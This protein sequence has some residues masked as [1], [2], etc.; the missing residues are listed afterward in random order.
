MSWGIMGIILVSAFV[1]TQWVWQLQY[2]FQRGSMNALCPGT[3]LNRVRFE[4]K[5]TVEIPALDCRCKEKTELRHPS[6]SASR[7]WKLAE[8]IS[9][10]GS[11]CRSKL[12]IYFQRHRGALCSCQGHFY[13]VGI[14]ICWYNVFTP[15]VICMYIHVYIYR[16]NIT[17]NKV[18]RRFRGTAAE[19]EAMP[20]MKTIGVSARF[21]FN[22]VLSFSSRDSDVVKRSNS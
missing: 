14:L 16:C 7:Y 22:L 12:P 5:M 6:A 13:P 17:A 9:V 18:K 15:M 20:R 2:R 10:T 1:G 19:A 21:S 3:D 11:L 8:T 4:A